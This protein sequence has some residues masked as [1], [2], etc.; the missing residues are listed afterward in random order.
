MSNDSD[1][2]VTVVLE[3]RDRDGAVS[4]SVFFELNPREQKSFGTGTGMDLVGGGLVVARVAGYA[5]QQ[6]AIPP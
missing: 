1:R 2:A 5:D 4:A 3:G 6:V